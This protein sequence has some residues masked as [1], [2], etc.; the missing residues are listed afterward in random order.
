MPIDQLLWPRQLPQ[1]A[2]AASYQKKAFSREFPRR[3]FPTDTASEVE[4]SDSATTFEVGDIKALSGASGVG[5]SISGGG[6]R[7]VDLVVHWVVSQTARQWG[8]G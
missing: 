6:R 5:G 1:L 8:I 3:E 7:D 2:F 4:L